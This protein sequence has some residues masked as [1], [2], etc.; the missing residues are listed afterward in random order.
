MKRTTQI[1]ALAWQLPLTVLSYAYYRIIRFFLRRA[2]DA[3]HKQRLRSGETIQW[4]PFSQ[5]VDLPLALP[6]LMVTGPRWN[7][8][9]VLANAGPFRVESDVSIKTSQAT[10]SAK[11]W[12]LVVYKEKYRTVAHI[13]SIEVTNCAPQRIIL[14]P[15]NY[16]FCIRLYNCKNQVTFPE[17]L[18]DESWKV[19][20]RIA[21]N[22]N[23]LYQ[24]YLSKIRNTKTFFYYCLHYYI[25]NVLRWANRLPLS[26]V[27]NE[28]LPVG[29]PDTAFIF[30]YLEKGTA[31]RITIR[32]A[33]LSEATIYLA[34]YNICSF[35]VFWQ[36]ID[37]PRYVS[38]DAPC[39]G[40]YLIRIQSNSAAKSSRVLLAS[41]DCKKI[42]AGKDSVLKPNPGIA[43]KR[44]QQSLTN[45]SLTS[46]TE[47]GVVK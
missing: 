5:V 41:V 2:V 36:T 20:S 12:S 6:M 42:N 21:K 7:C 45:K 1:A 23:L 4:I 24:A 43:E 33:I 38:K 19:E 15:G 28:Y 27:R 29:N 37:E 18:I 46:V 25:F 16:F 47:K 3:K 31:L 26:F 10:E 34:V 22:E 30:G 32:P 35:P 39:N 11:T 13:S 8:H 44:H 40:H 9:A 14:E 17:I